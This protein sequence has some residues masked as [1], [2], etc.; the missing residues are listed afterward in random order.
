MITMLK[1]SCINKDGAEDLNKASFLLEIY[2]LEIQFCSL[3]DNVLRMKAVYPK[4]LN[5]NSAI[6]DPRIM[7]V[8][9]EEGGKMYM[10]QGK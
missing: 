7:G 6:S 5:L 2:C 1:S 4:T 3:T 10:A 8:I 9:R